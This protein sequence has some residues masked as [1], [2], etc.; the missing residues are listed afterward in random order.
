M[1]AP[2]AV[3]A[4]PYRANVYTRDHGRFRD[5]RGANVL[6]YF[7]HGLGDWV[8]LAYALPLLETSNRYW[9]TRFG[10]DN[11]ALMEGHPTVTPVYLGLNGTQNGDGT[12]FGNRNFG[13]GDDAADGAERELQLP[14]SLYE[15]CVR[16]RI[17][18]L[19]WS[20]FLETSGGTAFPYHSKARYFARGAAP[21]AQ[22]VSLD[23][24]VPLKSSLAFDVPAW[25]GQWVESRLRNML[26]LSGRKLCIIVRNGYTSVGKNWGHR[27][28]EE[29]PVARR[30]EGEECREF[31]RLMRSKDPRWI[32]LVTED[33]LFEGDDTVRAAELNCCSYAEVFGVVNSPSI[34]C[35]LVM[36]VLANIADLCV[37][38]PAGPYHL[39]MTKPELPTVGVWLEHLPSWYDEP[40]DASIHVV[41]RNVR[42]H[43]LDRKPGS[44]FEKGQL[45]FRTLTVDTRVVHGA[46]VMAAVEAL[47]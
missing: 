1:I 39:C 5:V 38:V 33:R 34:P 8:Q 44:F 28:R 46:D 37:G 15:L 43:A 24:G 27:W 47:L 19:L 26:G 30:R 17:G 3:H 16:E 6:I 35:G 32:F 45:R 12:A 23:F 40:K 36:K 21:A 25:A 41:S 13:L 31:M 11:V 29:L 18:A 7:P 14:A 42:D 4:R 22:T 2:A 9:I 10:D 20:P